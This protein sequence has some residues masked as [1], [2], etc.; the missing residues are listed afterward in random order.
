MKIS[1]TQT[2]I[3]AVNRFFNSPKMKRFLDMPVSKLH[4]FSR[5]KTILESQTGKNLLFLDS[6]S[7][8]IMS[9]KQFVNEIK[10]RPLYQ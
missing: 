2:E 5:V 10:N 1:L 9:C 4:S 3:F 6:R 8:K 7:N